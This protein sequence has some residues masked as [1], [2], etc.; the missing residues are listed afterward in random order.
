MSV[1]SGEGLPAATRLA[2][3]CGTEMGNPGATSVTATPALAQGLS[4]LDAAISATLTAFAQT[5]IANKPAR[6]PPVAPSR[7]TGTP[8]PSPYLH[9]LGLSVRTY[10]RML[11]IADRP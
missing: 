11:T 5:Q 7:T 10:V 3:P 2:I 4:T 9:W 8:A 6:T 1:A